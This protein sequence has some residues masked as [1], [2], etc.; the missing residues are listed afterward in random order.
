MSSGCAA[1]APFAE[2]TYLALLWPDDG[3]DGD[4]DTPLV[5]AT[6]VVVMEGGRAAETGL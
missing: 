5:G 3:V 4:D 6:V 2:T 1:V